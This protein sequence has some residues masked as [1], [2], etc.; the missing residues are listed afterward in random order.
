MELTDAIANARSTHVIQFL[1]IAYLEVLR[2]RRPANG[3]LRE[4]TVLPLHGPSDIRNRAARLR[5]QTSAARAGVTDGRANL[6][7]E[8]RRVFELAVTRLDS[9]SASSET[10]FDEKAQSSESSSTRQIVS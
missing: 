7:D 4:L 8:M 2:N 9:L 1:L 6:L 5:S 3:L 10:I